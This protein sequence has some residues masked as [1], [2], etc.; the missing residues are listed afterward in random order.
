MVQHALG[1]QHAAD[2][3]DALLDGVGGV[4]ALPPPVVLVV[5]HLPTVDAPRALAVLAPSPA[6]L[7]L[8]Q[9]RGLSLDGRV[10]AQAE[11]QTCS[12]AHTG[13]G[14]RVPNGTLVE[15]VLA[16]LTVQFVEGGGEVQALAFGLLL[17]HDGVAVVLIAADEHVLAWVDANDLL[18]VYVET[19]VTSRLEGDLW[20][21]RKSELAGGL[22]RDT[23]LR[24]KSNL[25]FRF[26]TRAEEKAYLWR[27]VAAVAGGELVERLRSDVAAPEWLGGDDVVQRRE[28]LFHR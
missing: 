7:G 23:G 13:A 3:V 18:F 19:D 12:D 6:L 22:R 14:V 10:L 15:E 4:L 11:P 2:F 20:R 26:G 24:L 8:E 28:R 5:E 9:G 21:S 17:P 16:L 27:Q 1:A 25:T